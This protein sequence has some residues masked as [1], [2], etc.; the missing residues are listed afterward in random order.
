MGSE[1]AQAGRTLTVLRIVVALNAVAILVQAVTAGRLLNGGAAGAHAMGAGAV[2]LLGLVQLVAAVVLWR[3][4]RGPGRPALASLA[5][6]LLGFAQSAVGGAG[7]TAL[8]VPFG[9][10]LFGG[11]VA[12]VVWTWPRA[13]S[14][15]PRPVPGEG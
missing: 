11:V 5:L 15:S 2:H 4:G 3:P 12:M 6:L 10:T 8:H 13:G 1:V 7:N 14:G 9:V